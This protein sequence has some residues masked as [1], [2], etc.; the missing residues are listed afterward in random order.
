MTPVPASGQTSGASSQ[1][2]ATTSIGEV[3]RHLGL[4]PDTLRYYERR[5]VVPSPARDTS[6]RRTY[7]AADVHLLEVLLHLRNTGMPLAD[8]ATFTHLVSRDPD[9]VAERLQL[10]R[11]HR[12]RVQAEQARIAAS[13]TV[14][15]LK[16]EDYSARMPN[17]G[18][19]AR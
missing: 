8:I 15:A 2:A 12:Q 17:S 6:G 19:C 1:T 3:A 18:S 11:T 4:D 10:L 9:G 7:S 5:G 13:L 16:I 14:I